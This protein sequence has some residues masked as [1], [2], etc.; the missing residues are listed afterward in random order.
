MVRSVTRFQICKFAHN[1][2]PV[3]SFTCVTLCAAVHPFLS[4]VLGIILLRSFTLL[5][6]KQKGK[7][8]MPA[9]RKCNSIRC[10]PYI[11]EHCY[12]FYMNMVHNS[13]ICLYAVISW[14]WSKL[15]SYISISKTCG[16]AT[17][18]PA[19]SWQLPSSSATQQQRR[20]ADGW[21]AR[22]KPACNH[23][24]QSPS[25][26]RRQEGRGRGLGTWHRS[27]GVLSSL[28]L[29]TWLWPCLEISFCS[30]RSVGPTRKL[31]TLCCGVFCST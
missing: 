22:G 29:L 25:S 26:K 12:I 23:T 18:I 11:Q 16:L 21:N 9:R 30:R 6:S 7:M 10:F 19:I 4:A 17:H 14:M 5:F 1:I 8:I 15:C 3:Y 13:K 2:H 31:A 28:L 24:H 20:I 27:E